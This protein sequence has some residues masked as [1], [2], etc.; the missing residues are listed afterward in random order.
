MSTPYVLGPPVGYHP[1][2]G[3]LN[4]TVPPQIRSEIYREGLALVHA[5]MDAEGIPHGPRKPEP[6]TCPTHP[7]NPGGRT[8]AGDLWCGDCR[9][10]ENGN[11][12]LRELPPETIPHDETEPPTEDER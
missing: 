5:A 1:A 3:D 11:P 7:A 12:R 2:V 9:R 8:G 4:D 10:T 6:T